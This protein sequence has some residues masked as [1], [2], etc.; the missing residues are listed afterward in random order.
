MQRVANNIYS[1][2]RFLIFPLYFFNFD[3]E[4]H[5]SLVYIN[6]TSGSNEKST[7]L[8]GCATLRRGVAGITSVFNTLLASIPHWI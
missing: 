7:E 4:A 6:C 8:G 3:R 2:M 1:L 5:L